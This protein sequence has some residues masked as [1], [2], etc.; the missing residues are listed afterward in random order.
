ML[1]AGRLTPGNPAGVL[2]DVLTL[3]D[4]KPGLRVTVRHKIDRREGDWW[5]EVTGTI[6][7]VELQKTGSW[8]AHSKDNRL[9]LQRIRLVR[10]DG[11]ETVLVC[12]QWTTVEPA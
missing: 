6:A 8:Y 7:S 12:D 11:E 2:D 10:D 1:P 9:W 3:D 5:T 4:L